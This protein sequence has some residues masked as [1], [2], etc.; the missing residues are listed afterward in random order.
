[1]ATDKKYVAYYRLS[2]STGESKL[3]I[4]AQKTIV[5]HYYPV[6]EKE[7][8]EIK[9]GKNIEDRDVLKACI[10]FCLETGS[11]LVTA[12]VDRLSRSTEDCL[13]IYKQLNK[14]LYACDIPGE[15][16][17]FTLTLYS[18]FAERERELIGI[19]TTNAL[20]EKVKQTGEWRTGTKDFNN[21]KVAKLGRAAN[22]AKAANNE[23]N[24][25]AASLV[26]A[27]KK[28]GQT[29]DSIAQEL[30]KAQFKT[31]RGF[32]FNAVQVKRIYDK[33]CVAA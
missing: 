30:N 6:L 23:N 2:K 8:T 11:Y 1:M 31:S 3:G 17:K 20:K 7:F 26:C 12:K 9:S 18:A 32:A 27:L 10:Q 13:S 21:G 16:D 33:F 5:R 28:E 25:R 22:I 29:F 15:I 14:R 4:D 24:L 19:R